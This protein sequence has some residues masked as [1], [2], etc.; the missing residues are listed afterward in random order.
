M[1]T[2][3]FKA[4]YVQPILHGTKTN[5]IRKQSKRLPT[6]GETVAFSVG[7]RRPFCHARVVRLNKI[8]KHAISAARL[9]QLNNCKIETNEELIKITFVVTKK[10]RNKF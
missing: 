9:T 10:L 4:C 8:N 5:T 3:W 7:P 1:K 2:L 6:I